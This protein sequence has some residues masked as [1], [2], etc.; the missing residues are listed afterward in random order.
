MN[1][2]KKNNLFPYY[3][4]VVAIGTIAF[5]F[6]NLDIYL[7]GFGFIPPS[8]IFIGLLFIFSLPLI[9]AYSREAISFPLVLWC[10]FFLLISLI[11]LPILS[12]T[13]VQW[14]EFRKRGLAVF[15]LLMT[16]VIFSKHTIVQNCAR[17]AIFVAVI[18][19]I[20]NNFYEFLNPFAFTINEGTGLLNSGRPAGFYINPN[21]SGAALVLGMILSIGIVNAKYRWAFVILVGIGV[22]LTFSRGAI[23]ELLLVTLIFVATKTLNSSNI[24]LLIIIIFIGLNLIGNINL[25]DILPWDKLNGTVQLRLE[26][27]LSGD[28]GDDNDRYGLAKAAWDLFTQNPLFGYGIGYTLEWEESQSTHNTYLYYM[29][30]HGILGALILPTL[31]LAITWQTRGETRN[32]ALAFSA[33]ILVWGVFSHNIMGQ[34]HMLISF[35]LMAAMKELNKIEPKKQL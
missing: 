19:A 30:D 29:V 31:V 26:N 5:F 21:D 32:V 27:F 33:F 34:R 18:I 10:T 12:A 7:A 6:T 2:S 1:L 14:E 28:A 24:I 11:C 20:I 35:A 15:F 16:T 9:I 22:F 13:E 8:T 17:K 23:L 4:V 3:Q 25:L